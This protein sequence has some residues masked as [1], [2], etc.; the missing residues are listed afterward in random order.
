[1][2]FV[3]F[4][5]LPTFASA[6]HKGL[7]TLS[8]SKKNPPKVGLVFSGGGAK[9]LSYVGVL[10]ELDRLGIKIDCIAGTSAGAIIAALYASG[11]T[12]IQIEQLIRDV[13]DIQDVVMDT[14]SRRNYSSF[15]KSDLASYAF[16]F[17][18]EGVKIKLPRSI[19]AGQRFYNFLGERLA[20]VDTI[21]DFNRLPIPFFTIATQL[22]TG[23][24]RVFTKGYLPDVVRA[25]AALPTLMDPITIGGNDYID[26]GI[27]DNFPVREMRKR[28]IDIII[29]CNVQNNLGSDQSIDTFVALVNQIINYGIYKR[30]KAEIE[31]LDIYISPDVKEHS[32][33]DFSNFDAL[34]EKGREAALRQEK[35]LMKL[36]ALQKK[37]ASH[38]VVSK[39]NSIVAPKKRVLDSLV[40][41]KLKHYDHSYMLGVLNL[42][43]GDSLSH[44]SISE[45]LNLLRTVGH[46]G[47]SRYQ[48]KKNKKTGQGYLQLYFKERSNQATLKLG[49]YYDPIYRASLLTNFTVHHFIEKNDVLSVRLMLGDIFRYRFRYYVENSYGL[50][51]GFYSD[52]DWFTRLRPYQASKDIY[53]D[54]VTKRLFI[55]NTR[56]FLKLG[57]D[58][59]GFRIGGFHK[60]FSESTNA[61][62]NPEDL[63][64][65][66][67]KVNQNVFQTIHYL[68]TRVM[69][70]ID[71]R[72]R[73]YMPKNGLYLKS[74]FDTYFFSEGRTDVNPNPFS[75]FSQLNGF[76]SYAQTWGR[77]TLEPSFSTGLNFMSEDFYIPYNLGGYTPFKL[78]NYV[79]FYGRSFESTTLN[80]YYKVGLNVHFELAKKHQISLFSNAITGSNTNQADVHDDEIQDIGLALGYTYHSLLGPISLKLG[81]SG[82]QKPQVFFSIGTKY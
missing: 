40:F 70:K 41:S 10:E 33:T 21:N 18:V 1:M 4:L 31:A 77:F 9:G 63:E 54:K 32:L 68:G 12:G 45:K 82:T 62:V 11:Y 73:V 15:R 30:S 52:F 51:Y 50:S 39:K 28:G 57:N 25:S 26:G 76:V 36:A 65:E 43:K 42:K 8:F 2:C 74:S 27:V 53:L 38:E 71:T 5:L 6:Q 44:Q 48:W 37:Y 46:F 3:L 60:Y 34:F 49:V 13:E 56:L 19:S 81:I 80:H 66:E 47:L 59:Y 14:Q 17:N 79:H 78:D 64:E 55:F 16:T 69:F 29:G 61:F 7:D 23:R 20:H 35:K 75:L 22:S 72:D 67:R 58:N 24:K